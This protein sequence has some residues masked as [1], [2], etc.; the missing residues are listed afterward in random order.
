MHHAKVGFGAVLVVAS[1]LAMSLGQARAQAVAYQPNVGTIPDGIGMTVVP[2]VSA[3]RRYVRVSVDA[4]FQT[5]NGFQNLGVPFAVSGFGGAG[6]AGAGL[7]LAGGAGAAAGRW[8]GRGRRR[9]TRRPPERRRGDGDG[10]PGH[11]RGDGVVSDPGSRR[12][13]IKWLRLWRPGLWLWLWR[14]GG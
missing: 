3:D 5:V 11:R 4:T 8:S 13:G 6:N 1:W 7:G 10:R 2:V 12:S 9:W 14:S